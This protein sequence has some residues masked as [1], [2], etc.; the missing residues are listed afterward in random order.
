MCPR[1]TGPAR[2]LATEALAGVAPLGRSTATLSLPA[3]A[4][5]RPVL[6]TARLE[7]VEDER[8]LDRI[9]TVVGFR[10]L[11]FDAYRGFFLN[12]RATGT[13]C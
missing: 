11:R 10:T 2:H 1:R 9:D 8:V 7:L 6:Y 4:P 5:D 3:E 12:D 13:M